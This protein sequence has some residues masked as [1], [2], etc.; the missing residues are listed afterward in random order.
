[1]A[2]P[3]DVI[4]LLAAQPEETLDGMA[5]TLQSTI[6]QA[7]A[8]LELVEAAR[9][10]RGRRRPTRSD[11]PQGTG[12][13]AHYLKRDELFQIVAEQGKPVSPAEIHAILIERH[14]DIASA[15][16]RTG[17]GRL[18]RDGRLVRLDEGRYAVNYEREIGADG[19]NGNGSPHPLFRD[20]GPS[21]ETGVTA[22]VSD[23]GSS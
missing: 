3:K 12:S 11:V 19:A 16:V 10:R 1:M 7:Q 18:V 8:Q 5:A 2:A 4:D 14:Y 6:E 13:R 22:P 20:D 17:M 9:N 21:S 23:R 15:A